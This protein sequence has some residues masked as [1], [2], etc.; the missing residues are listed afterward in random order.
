LVGSY[1]SGAQAEIHVETIQKNWRE[2]M[3]ALDIDEQL[4][5]R[6]DL[7]FEEYEDVHDAHNHDEDRA[8]EEFTVPDGEFVFDGWGRMG[9]RKYQYV[10]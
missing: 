7:T 8:V 10:E 9:E 6:Y 1:G 4:D 3:D 2:E 5:A